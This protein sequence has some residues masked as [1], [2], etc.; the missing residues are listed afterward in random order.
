[1]IK[2]NYHKVIILAVVKSAK[3]E[4]ELSYSVFMDK[5]SAF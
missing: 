1:M 3:Q 2:I 5:G 4:M